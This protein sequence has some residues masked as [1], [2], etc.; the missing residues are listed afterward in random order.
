MA[1]PE[2]VHRKI[3]LGILPLR[4]LF[5]TDMRFIAFILMG[6]LAWSLRITVMV[7]TLAKQ[8]DESIF[9]SPGNTGDYFG[10]WVFAGEVQ[11]VRASKIMG[12][13]II[14]LNSCL[15]QPMLPLGSWDKPGLY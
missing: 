10:A 7:C 8:G 1:P 15:R 13:I 3:R 12:T 11:R 9:S 4:E 5:V 14:L 2:A 6:L